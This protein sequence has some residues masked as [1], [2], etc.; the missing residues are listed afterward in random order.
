MALNKAFDPLSEVPGLKRMSPFVIVAVALFL[1]WVFSPF[2]IIGAGERGVV[3]NQL[4][5]IE[6]KILPEGFS[7]I[8]PVIQRVIKMDVRIRKSDTRATAASKDLQTVATEIVL[9][10][11]L[12]PDKVNKI[13]QEI[14]LEYE[15]RIIDPSV[16]E[17]VKA[18]CAEFTA[19]ELITKR[20]LVKDA[21]KTSLHKRLMTSHISLDELNIT[22]FQFSK[23]FNEAI[24]SKQTAEQ[25][26]LKAGRDL[27]RVRIEGQQ[28]VVQAKAEAESQRIQKETISPII[29]QLRA[30][31]KWDGK[32]P[33]VLGGSGAMPF[34]NIDAGSVKK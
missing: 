25:L 28:K 23:I 2:V 8:I 18:V 19:E 29:L 14:G 1:V 12:F 7:F 31:E 10:F 33:Q 21:I 5:G 34:I 22:D 17:I 3:F 30:I 26:A 16:Q 24:E 20:Q 27:E 9:N 13:Y 15:K 6:D 4:H 11:H 32:F